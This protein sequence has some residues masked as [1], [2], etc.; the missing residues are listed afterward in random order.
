MTD[1]IILGFVVAVLSAAMIALFYHRKTLSWRLYASGAIA[2]SV[3]LNA[4]LFLLCIGLVVY[5][6]YTSDAHKAYQQSFHDLAQLYPKTM[7]RKELEALHGRTFPVYKDT[8]SAGEPEGIKAG[9]VIFY[10]R[11]TDGTILAIRPARKP[12]L[13]S[14]E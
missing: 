8:F 6:S 1:M 14:V 9:N 7:T 4:I 5:L 13:E 2:I 11:R 3:I 12:W 10:F